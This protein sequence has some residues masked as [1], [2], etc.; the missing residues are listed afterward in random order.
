MMHKLKSMFFSKLTLVS[1]NLV[2]TYMLRIMVFL[3]MGGLQKASKKRMKQTEA[4]HWKVKRKKNEEYEESQITVIY[5]FDFKLYFARKHSFK[6]K[7]F[8]PS[9]FIQSFYALQDI[10][11]TVTIMYI[12][13]MPNIK[14]WYNIEIYIN[15]L[16]TT[17]QIFIAM[18]Y[19]MIMSE[20]YLDFRKIPLF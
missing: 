8:I 7:L 16:N 14:L 11:N 3:V 2:L 15:R 12:I 9:N 13:V 1:N 4:K 10:W 18:D 5:I 20:K 6:K 19:L 17:T